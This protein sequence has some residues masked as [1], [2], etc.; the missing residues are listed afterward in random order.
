MQSLVDQISA[1]PYP[2]TLADNKDFKHIWALASLNA[3]AIAEPWEAKRDSVL[4]ATIDAGVAFAKGAERCAA[5]RDA[6]REA[7]M[8][9]FCPGLETPFLAKRGWNRSQNGDSKWWHSRH[10]NILRSHIEAIGIEVRT[11]FHPTQQSN[12]VPV[13]DTPS[14]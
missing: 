7:I 14:T 9:M 12:P 1:N 5:E 8:A 11:L 10:G 4:Q 6:L 13:S 3:A 2:Y